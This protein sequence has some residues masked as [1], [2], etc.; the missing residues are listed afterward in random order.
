ME[1]DESII[2][3]LAQKEDID[4]EILRKEEFTSYLLKSLYLIYALV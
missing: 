4:I 2:I 1:L 3:N